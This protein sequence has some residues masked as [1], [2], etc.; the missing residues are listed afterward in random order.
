MAAHRLDE[1]ANL[2]VFNASFAFGCTN[3]RAVKKARTGGAMSFPPRSICAFRSLPGARKKNDAMP[4]PPSVKGCVGHHFLDSYLGPFQ[5][6]FSSRI[7]NWERSVGGWS[8]Y[9]D[10][11]RAQSVQVWV[12]SSLPILIPSFV[13]SS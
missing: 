7:S 12:T 4:P 6:A 3:P 1:I 13:R 8:S 9:V 10:V 2:Q 5:N 11:R